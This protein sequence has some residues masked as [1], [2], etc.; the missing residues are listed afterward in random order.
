[1]QQKEDAL[2]VTSRINAFPT[3]TNNLLFL[4]QSL[5]KQSGAGR[6]RRVLRKCLYTSKDAN[7]KK[8][9]SKTM[10]DAANG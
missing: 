3:R 9:A 4:R 10:G 2:A 1:M 8:T 6:A 5:N 7:Q